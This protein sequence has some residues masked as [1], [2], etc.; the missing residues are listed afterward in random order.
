MKKIIE[1]IKVLIGKLTSK[2]AS[3]LWL[4]EFKLKNY[5]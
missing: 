5:E 1:A 3:F 4:N 2:S